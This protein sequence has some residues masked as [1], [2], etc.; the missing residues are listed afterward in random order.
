MAQHNDLGKWGEEFA[1]N[2][3]VDKGYTLYERDWKFGKRDLDIV[4][5]NPNHTILVFIEVKT[6]SANELSLP[7]QAVT[8]QKMKSVALAAN[9]FI[10]ERNITDEVQFDVISITG[11][12]AQNASLNHIETAFNPMLLF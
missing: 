9:A 6:R 11:T 7:E 1:A 8:K 2:Y 12:S 5:Y 4:A 3:L 10:K